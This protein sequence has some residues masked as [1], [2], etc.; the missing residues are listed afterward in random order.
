M[1]PPARRARGGLRRALPR[2]RPRE[3]SSTARCR[4]GSEPGTPARDR[5]GALRARAAPALWSP[6]VR[7]LMLAAANTTARRSGLERSADSSACS[8]HAPTPRAGSAIVCCASATTI[9]H[10]EL[11][12]VLGRRVE[13]PHH[14]GAQIV[15]LEME[16][17]ASQRPPRDRASARQWPRRRRCSGARARAGECRCRGRRRGARVRS[18]EASRATG[19]ECLRARGRRGAST[20]RRDRQARRAHP[21]LRALLRRRPAQLRSSKEP[22]NTPRRSNTNR[23]SSFNDEYDHSTVARSVWCRSTV[24]RRPPASSRNRSSSSAGDLRR[25]HRDHA[26]G[27][28][29]DGE[30]DAV[31][32]T[33]DHRDRPGVVVTGE[34][35]ARLGRACALDEQLR[36]A[37]VRDRRRPRRCREAEASGDGSRAHRARRALLGW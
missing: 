9:A 35:E 2:P 23:S 8:A 33:A 26:G 4:R 19:S 36:G 34:R 21:S 22:A 24:A 30:R 17:L 27:G 28:Q 3:P 37:V 15:E 29:L 16:T 14:R 12:V 10:R 7:A 13:R 31:E 20:S 25:A 5:H 1:R 6:R 11:R 32:A 18:G